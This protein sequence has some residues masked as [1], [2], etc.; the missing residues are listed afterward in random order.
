[1]AGSLVRN[2]AKTS[3]AK[4]GV[5]FLDL[6]PPASPIGAV[7]RKI[8]I[9][10][11]FPWGAPNTPRTCYG[12]DD[13][14]AYFAPKAFAS[15]VANYSAFKAFVGAKFPGPIVVVRIDATDAVARS[16]SYTVTGGAYVGT[17]PYK[18]ALGNDVTITWAA[19]TDANSAHRNLTISIGTAYSAL[20][21]NVTTSTLTTL[22]D[23]Y[24]TWTATSSPSALPAAAASATSTTAGADGTAVAADYVGTSS[25]N[26]GIRLFYGSSY[27]VNALVVAECPSGLIASVNAGLKAYADDAGKNG[28]AILCS[29]ASQTAAT[30]ATYG[31]SFANTQ[32]KV[33]GIWPRV[34]VTDTRSSTFPSMTIDANVMFACACVGVDPWESPEG[35]NS[36]FYFSEVTGLETSNTTDTAYEAMLDGGMSTIFIDDVLGPLVRGAVTTNT[37]SGQ[38]DIVRSMYRAYFSANVAGY[39]IRYVGAPLQVDLTNRRLG[40]RVKPLYDSIVAFCADEQTKGHINGYTVDPFGPNVAADIDAGTWSI[41]TAIDT[42]APLRQLIIRTQIGSTVVTTS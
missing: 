32:S 23:P 34:T 11:D 21:E 9:V 35:V 31:S 1:M 16:S 42:Y 30:A 13:V 5:N 36:T 3:D 33:A 25:S 40:E 39:A 26:V 38:T 37:T 28:I 29:V 2:I 41:A 6:A 19:A 18:G 14:L 15:A 20:Y 7:S 4:Y 27:N 17:C 24:I 10:G 22:G 8:G 12:F